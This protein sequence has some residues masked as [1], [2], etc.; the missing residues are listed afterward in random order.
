MQKNQEISKFASL[1]SNI[2][3]P[4]IEKWNFLEEEKKG[5]VR[6]IKI[7]EK[8]RDASEF[9]DLNSLVFEGVF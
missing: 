8:G 3:K 4:L 2:I 1:D 9:F 5:R 6:Y 7:T